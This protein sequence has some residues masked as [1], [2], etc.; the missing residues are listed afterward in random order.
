M[1]PADKGTGLSQA[2]ELCHGVSQQ[3]WQLTQKIPRER[4]VLA[5]SPVEGGHKKNHVFPLGNWDGF[6]QHH[7][8]ESREGGIES[9]S[10]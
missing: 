7:H 4:D 5:S 2:A 9:C 10:D 8:A 6:W 3:L 1:H